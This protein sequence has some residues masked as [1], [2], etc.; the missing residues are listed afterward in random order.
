MRRIVYD[1]QRS[2]LEGDTLIL[3]TLIYCTLIYACIYK[4]LISDVLGHT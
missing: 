1:Q 2:S 4:M 3:F